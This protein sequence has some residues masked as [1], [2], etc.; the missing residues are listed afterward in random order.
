MMIV[1]VIAFSYANGTLSSIIQN[2]DQT[3]A[4]FTEKL[5]VLNRIYKDYCLPLDL[6]IMLRKNLK[7][8]YQKNF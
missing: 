1:G 6:Y 3:N 8:E 2:F 5:M 4:E 7:Y